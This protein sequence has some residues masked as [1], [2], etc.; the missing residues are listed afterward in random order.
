MKL[1]NKLKQ[2]EHGH[3]LTLQRPGG[4]IGVPFERNFNSILRRDRQK[5]FPMCASLWVGRRKE[6]ILGFVSKNDE[7]NLVHKGLTHERQM[8]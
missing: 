6:P 3:L 4:H 8:H 5:K 1:L 2:G 7:K